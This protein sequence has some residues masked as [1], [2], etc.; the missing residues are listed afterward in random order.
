MSYVLLLIAIILFYPVYLITKRTILSLAKHLNEAKE[1]KRSNI[2]LSLFILSLMILFLPSVS[3][4]SSKLFLFTSY[5]HIVPLLAAS[6]LTFDIS[7]LVILILFLAEL[8][9]FDEVFKDFD[10]ANSIKNDN[11]AVA[12]LF[13]AT[14]YVFSVMLS[15]PITLLA[16][17]LF[18]SFS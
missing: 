16:N 10:P 18:L 17:N 14:T 15:G 6:L 3:F 11:I 9:I 12:L 13:L 7:V 5:N 2:A 4:L 8:T 1:L